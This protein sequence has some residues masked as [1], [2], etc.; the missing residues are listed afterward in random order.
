MNNIY[1]V[2]FR[3]KCTF[4]IVAPDAGAAREFYVNFSEKWDDSLVPVQHFGVS[5]QQEIRNH[6]DR[7]DVKKLGTADRETPAGVVTSRTTFGKE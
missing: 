3:G 5:E 1:L 2:R 6:W 4:T 7:F